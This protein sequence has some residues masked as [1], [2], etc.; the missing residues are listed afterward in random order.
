MTYNDYMI[1]CKE[2]I[3]TFERWFEIYEQTRNDPSKKNFGYGIRLETKNF[4]D[5]EAIRKALPFRDHFFFLISNK[6]NREFPIHVDGIPGNKNAAS[7]N[8]PLEKC[9]HRSPTTWYKCDTVKF[10]NLD[11]SFFLENTDDAE[12]IY[13]DAMLSEHKLPYLFRSDV[14]HRGYCNI[15]ESGFRII[16]KWELDFDNWTNACREF[17]DRNYI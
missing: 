3:V 16:L 12:E 6:R 7:V 9:D 10:K 17:Q 13:S 2:P 5:L 11:N 15:D 8:W 1:L 4:P 14:L